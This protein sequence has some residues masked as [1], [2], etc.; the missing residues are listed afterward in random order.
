MCERSDL[1]SDNIRELLFVDNEN[2]S[3]DELSEISSTHDSDVQFEISDE[4]EYSELN[5]NND[6]SFEEQINLEGNN[7]EN[8][9]VDDS[10]LVNEEETDGWEEWKEGDVH[11]DQFRWVLNSGYKPPQVRNLPLL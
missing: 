11:F 8:E 4:L 9:D 5:L 2:D 6:A 1:R 3:T 7:S 10:N